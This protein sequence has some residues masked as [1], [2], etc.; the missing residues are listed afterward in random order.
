M[1]TGSVVATNCT[2]NAAKVIARDC[3][4]PSIC[5]VL[6]GSI[7]AQFGVCARCRCIQRMKQAYD[8][9]PGKAAQPVSKPAAKRLGELMQDGSPK[10]KRMRTTK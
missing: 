2:L 6:V 5:H 3:H 1:D 4:V 8:C 7:E 9:Q 10:S